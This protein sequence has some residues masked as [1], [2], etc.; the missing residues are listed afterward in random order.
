M[1]TTT[2]YPLVKI[3]SLHLIEPFLTAESVQNLFSAL[4]EM[5][6]GRRDVWPSSEEAFQSLKA[7]STIRGWDERVVK[8]FIVSFIF[9]LCFKYDSSIV[10]RSMVFDRYLLQNTLT[11]K[12]A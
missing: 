1:L 3:S 12:R 9:C 6:G 8:I 2:Y 10:N 11:C 7:Q 5:S 4:S